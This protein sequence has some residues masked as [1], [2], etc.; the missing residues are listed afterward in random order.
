MKVT[1]RSSI[2]EIE[3]LIDNEDIMIDEDTKIILYRMY[4][5]IIEFIENPEEFEVSRYDLF[6]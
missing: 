2:Y 5:K 3:R 4:D 6:G 1:E